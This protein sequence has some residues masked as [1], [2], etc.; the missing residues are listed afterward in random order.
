MQGINTRILHQPA[1]KEDVYH[2]IRFPVYDTAAYAFETSEAIANA[3][4]GKE[5]AHQYTRG[6]NPT[7]EHFER[8]MKSV[9]GAHAAVAV[10]SG[11]AA[12]ANTCMA[13]CKSGDNL[14]VSKFLFGNSYSLFNTTLPA[15]G[16][17][18]RFA[19]MESEQELNKL[20]DEKTRG[21]FCETITNPQL[22]VVDISG[23][24]DFCHAR[25]VPLIVDT[26]LTPPGMFQ[27]K[28][29]GIDVEVMSA[30]KYFSGGGTGIGGC[31]LD[32][33][34]YLWS[35]NPT[36]ESLHE[37]TGANALLARLKKEIFRN[38][39]AC[40]S[41]HNA[42]LLTLG[43]ETLTLRV[44]KTCRNAL[45]LAQWFQSQEQVKFISYPGLSSHPNKAIAEK[46]FNGLFGG[47]LTFDLEN[48]EKCFQFM[49][50]LQIIKRA[51][52]LNDN[53]S[54]I[55]HPESTIYCEFSDTQ[56][57]EQ[58]IRDTSVRLSAGI[59]DLP[60]LIND[61]EQALKG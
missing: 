58:G 19:N 7:V 38:F 48:R 1:E 54:L 50:R 21:V 49:D 61:L 46:Q 47:L 45:G 14:V 24:A 33:G 42:F 34:T 35:Q 56:K 30:T 11:M 3:F 39:G 25:N 31:I 36:L 17:N 29:A 23:L 5:K 51:T 57:S 41:P 55:I 53:R 2:A 32:H 20:I 4:Q 16:I 60:D 52:N 40:L 22:Q 26:T 9:T 28:L 37:K 6:S 12:I 8:M 10:A 27:G 15:L 44:E 59:E 13:L 18:I 43:M